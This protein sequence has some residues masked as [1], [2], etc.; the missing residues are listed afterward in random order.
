LGDFL[1]KPKSQR[2]APYQDTDC[3]QLSFTDSV[4][5]I[6][7]LSL[8]SPDNVRSDPFVNLSGP[9]T[10]GHV[11]EVVRTPALLLAGFSRKWQKKATWE[12]AI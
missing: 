4:G 6:Y 12:S 9:G 7:E 10:I 1:Y 2:S 8:Y 5:A 3:P 11:A